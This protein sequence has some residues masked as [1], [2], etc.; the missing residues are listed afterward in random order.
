M[1]LIIAVSCQND[2]G[3]NC[4]SMEV[5]TELQ[6]LPVHRKSFILLCFFSMADILMHTLNVSLQLNG[7]LATH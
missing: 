1:F 3:C 6:Q 4:S 5:M 2:K 7:G